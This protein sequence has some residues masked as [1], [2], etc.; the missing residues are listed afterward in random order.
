[1][2]ASDWLWTS[3]LLMYAKDTTHRAKI[4]EVTKVNKDGF[5]KPLSGAEQEFV[6][7]LLIDRYYLLNALLRRPRQ[8]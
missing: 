2:A 3:G 5:L 8:R 7:G 1:M 6:R 4:A